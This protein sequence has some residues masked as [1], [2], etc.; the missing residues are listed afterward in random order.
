MPVPLS[1]NIDTR[2]DDPSCA[3][4]VHWYEHA[5]HRGRTTWIR[6]RYVGYYTG[7]YHRKLEVPIRRLFHVHARGM[8]MPAV[9]SGI[10]PPY[11][12]RP[13]AAPGCLGFDRHCL[14]LRHRQCVRNDLPV[15][16]SRVL[17]GRLARSDGGILR[18]GRTV[19]WLRSWR[20]RDLPGSRDSQHAA[21]H[22]V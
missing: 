9:T 14:R 1:S 18:R 5:S 16:A 11:H 3:G 21:A 2:A 15:H 7:Q 19:V 4:D 12:G 8:L 13:S 22:A 10:L 6:P 17:L 20:D